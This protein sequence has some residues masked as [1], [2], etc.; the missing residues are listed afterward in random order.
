MKKSEKK[1]KM[2][3]KLLSRTKSGSANS[4]KSSTAVPEGH[5]TDPNSGSKPPESSDDE[6]EDLFDV[7]TFLESVGDTLV[8]RTLLPWVSEEI[9]LRDNYV[10]KVGRYIN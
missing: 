9:L 7:P 8:L 3:K 4:S 5:S 10:Q 1:L 2:P 6:A